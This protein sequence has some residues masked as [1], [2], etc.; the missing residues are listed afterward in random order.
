MGRP[1]SVS[2]GER[3]TGTDWV[4]SFQ[5]DH[6]TGRYRRLPHVAQSQ[7]AVAQRMKL[8]RGEVDRLSVGL[9]FRFIF[10]PELQVGLLAML[11]VFALIVLT[12]SGCF[13]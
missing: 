11:K 12:L 6:F 5:P 2:F 9:A 4:R 1:I 10:A 8:S 3:V 7:K 13:A